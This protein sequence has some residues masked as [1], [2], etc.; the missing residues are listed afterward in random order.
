MKNIIYILRSIAIAP[1]IDLKMKLTFILL[2]TALLNVNASSYSQNTKISLDLND[3]TVE[4]VFSE[5]MNK[6]D[7][8]ILYSAGE[9]NLQRKVSI[10]V[11]K[12]RVEKV[13]DIL[14]ANSI[15]NYNIVNK[16]IVLI[17]TIPKKGAVFPK[18]KIEKKREIQNEISGKVVDESGEALPGV[19]VVIE[20]TTRGIQTDLD[21]HYTIQADEGDILSFSFVGMQTQKI[22]IGST[23]T[24]NVTMLY[25]ENSLDDVI[26]VGYGAQK[27][28]TLTGSVATVSNKVIERSPAISVTNS[29]SGL[30]PGLV[31]LNRSGEPGADLSE[32]YIRGINTT[33]SNAP[34]VVVD[35]V[36]DPPQWQ[37]IS[38]DNIESISILKDAAAAIYGARAA[39][40]VILITTKRGFS[41]KSVITYS[42]NFASVMPT[43]IPEFANS[44]LFA[45]TVNQLLQEDGQSPRWTDNE[46]KK[47]YAG[48][49]PNYPSY[50]WYNE[51]LKKSS[52]QQMHNL[53]IRGGSD[54]IQYSIAGSFADQNSIFK[55]GI[56]QYNGYTIR[57]AIDAQ[58][59]ENI[60]I[61]LDLNAGWDKRI[62]PGANSDPF[63]WFNT[64]PM[65]PVYWDEDHPSSGIA[66]GY[67]PIM[68]TSSVAGERARLN[69][70]LT[71]KL[72]FDVKIPWVDGLMVDGYFAYVNNT[73]EDKNWKTPWTTYDYDK[74][75]KK[76]VPVHSGRIPSPQLDESYSFRRRPL[77]NL[78][79]AYNKSFEN[80]NI[81]A[82]IAGEQQQSTERTVTAARSN[83]ASKLLPDLFGGD[84]NTQ[85]NSGVTN[86]GSRQSLF[87]R[88]SYN[89]KE[90]YMVDVNARYDGSSVFAP[91]KRFGFFPG[92]SL[93][94]NIDT[95][96]FMENLNAVNLFK[97]RAS[98]GKMGNDNIPAYQ[99]LASYT[100]NVDHGYF[101]GEN[102]NENPGLYQIVEANPNITWEVATTSNIG[103][104][105]GLWQNRLSF[106]V[107]IFKQKRNN[108]LAKRNLSIPI[109]TYLEIP[110]ENIGEMQ[111]TGVEISVATRN[112]PRANG[113]KYTI[114]ANVGF[115]KS[116]IIYVDESPNIPEWQK[117]E[118]HIIGAGTYYH[119]LGIIRTEEQLNSLPVYP[120][121]IVGD[122]YY[123]DSNGDGEISAADMQTMDKSSIPKVTFGL[124][125]TFEYKNF[126]LFGNFAG[127]GGAWAYFHQNMRVGGWNGL[128]ELL[129]NRYTPGSMDSKYPNLPES[130]AVGDDVSGLRSDFWLQNTA[131]VRLKTL[132]LGY[133]FPENL[134][135]SM[136]LSSLKLYL[137]G[138]NLFT[139]TK[140]K[141]FDPESNDMRGAYYPQN[142]IINIGV[143]LSF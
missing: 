108:I 6:T 106:S 19:N 69:N 128:S 115:N 47:F 40:G 116:K 35:G 105:M 104:D 64:E 61:H 98:I 30:I 129:E 16:Q 62:S 51:I 122:L 50:N 112:E 136:H 109:F 95:E 92:V 3:A 45:E 113:F 125:F 83:Y 78:R 100:S 124:N 17:R 80:H 25:S 82:F 93:A 75:N 4:Q 143:R 65:I 33:G 127:Q 48:N 53:S 138:T 73:N 101:F 28:V 32:I 15:I 134:I 130:S 10:R 126:S 70:R 88:I 81:S 60:G 137:S 102:F 31:T 20:G 1:K 43:K 94:W 117:V 89:F 14:F 54:D 99:Y 133:N 139:I 91:G 123:E 85:T 141:W 52:G 68:M 121:T 97:L 77:Y 119:S 37:R 72:A 11:K 135:S 140:V 142:K 63:Q 58:V 2:L 46:V 18:N 55:Q 66:F 118:G 21:G 59:T 42:G 44:G 38:P 29:L 107:D 39:N 120:G 36:Q 41:G 13:L 34:L 114:G 22:K 57:S 8:K 49:D 87:G 74:D 86:R 5:I 24:I 111:N 67:N 71:T 131:F 103:I 56:H 27:K 7:F 76:Y 90:K 23:N 84:P 110:F 12:Q 132:E 26:V 79:I 9:I 96:G